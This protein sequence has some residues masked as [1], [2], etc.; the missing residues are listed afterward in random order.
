MVRAVAQGR[1]SPVRPL[2]EQVADSDGIDEG[3]SLLLG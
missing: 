2:I 1:L 3:R